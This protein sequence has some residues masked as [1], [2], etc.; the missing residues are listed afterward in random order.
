MIQFLS[1]AIAVVEHEGRFLVGQRS[2]HVPLGGLWEF[3]GGKIKVDEAPQAAA[4]RECL[5]ET[6]LRVHVTHC[7]LFHK[8][9]YSHAEITL[10][11]FAC[12]PVDPQTPPN[13]PFEWIARGDL[14]K[15]QFPDGNRPLLER[16][17]G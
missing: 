15:L 7:L 17:L 2:R 11:F 12:L 16:L 14:A 4:A 9:T 5:E 1:V 6:G 8:Q 13:P 3:P 10:H